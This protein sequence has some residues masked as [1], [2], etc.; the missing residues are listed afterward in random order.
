MPDILVLNV[1]AASVKFALVPIGEWWQGPRLRGQLDGIG[2]DVKFK[3]A[4]RHGRLLH[5]EMIARHHAPRSP[6]AALKFVFNWMSVHDPMLTIAAIG[7]RVA[8]GGILFDAPVVLDDAVFSA[9]RALEPL[10]PPQQHFNLAGV[11]AAQRRFPGALQVACFDTAFHRT[12][13]WEN[14]AFALPRSYYQEGVRRYGFHGLS[15]ENVIRR[16]EAVAP[17]VAAGRVVIAHLGNGASLCA[18]DNGRS[19]ATTMGFSTLDG[20]PMGTRCGALDPGVILYLIAEKRMDASALTHLLYDE[21]G[22]KGLS[23]ISHDL[24]T[25]NVSHQP[26]AV[27]AVRYLV[28]QIRRELGA[29]VAVLGGLDGLVFTGGIGEHSSRLRSAVC[30]NLDW[31]GLAIDGALNADNAREISAHG[32]QVRVFCL[33]TDEE[34][35]IARYTLGELAYAEAGDVEAPPLAPQHADEEIV[36]A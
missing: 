9:L 13:A 20:L 30:R 19:L 16:L 26:E 17:S 5:S 11:Q 23:G 32:S 10:A 35:V 4:R 27:E 15:C 2:H 1:G 31:L 25:L 33:P 28:G 22:L 29:M 6:L 34:A 21:S 7:H 18:A 3:V 12:I 24:R 36:P 8:H 14:E